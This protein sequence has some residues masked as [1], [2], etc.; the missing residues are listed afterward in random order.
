MVPHETLLAP[1]DHLKNKETHKNSLHHPKVVWV[2]HD[3]FVDNVKHC[4]R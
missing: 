1:H 2:L 3:F 4:E